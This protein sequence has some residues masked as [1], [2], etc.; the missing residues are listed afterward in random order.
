MMIEETTLRIAIIKAG[1][2]F[3]AEHGDDFPM[4][5][6]PLNDVVS[7]VLNYLTNNGVMV[8]KNKNPKAEGKRKY[9]LA[10]GELA[11]KADNESLARSYDLLAN[12]LPW[13]N[14]E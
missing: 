5:N 4:R 13:S 6:V 3:S 2:T 12:T 8:L 14:N 10:R 7:T 1:L 11:R 9:Y